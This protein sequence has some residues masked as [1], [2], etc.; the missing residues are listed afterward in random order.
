MHRLIKCKQI[1]G[2]YEGLSLK[3]YFGNTM[4]IVIAQSYASQKMKD[5]CFQFSKSELL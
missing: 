3:F 1:V 2:L 4:A 5:T